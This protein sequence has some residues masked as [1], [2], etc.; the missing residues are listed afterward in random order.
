MLDLKSEFNTISQA[1]AHQLDLKIPKT[2][3]EVQKIDC[4]TFETYKIVVSTFFMSNKDGRKRFF[5]KSFLLA[6]VKPNIVLKMPFLTMSNVD[7]NFQARDLQWKFYTTEN[8]LPTIKQAKLIKKK[9]V[10]SCRS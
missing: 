10:C 4:T 5:E 8:V 1:F 6:D 9:K 2:N 7:V 3:V